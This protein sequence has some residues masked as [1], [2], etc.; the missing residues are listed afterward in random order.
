MKTQLIDVKE[1]VDFKRAQ[2][3]SIPGVHQEKRGQPYVY[4]AW[5]SLAVIFMM[6]L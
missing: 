6:I 3:K 5:I 1:D 4:I 2:R